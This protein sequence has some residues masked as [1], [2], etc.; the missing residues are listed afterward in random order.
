MKVVKKGITIIIS[1]VLWAI[2]LLAALFAFTTLATKNQTDVASLAG[3]TPMI[4]ES[5]SMAPTFCKGDLIVIRQCDTASL[6]EGDIITFHTIIENEYALNTHRI[7]SISEQNGVRS[8]VTKGDNNSIADT[9][10]ISDGDIV[11]KY[12]GKV[13]GLGKVM[14]FLSGSVGFLVIIVL[15]LLLFFIYQIY[16]LIMV[17]INLKKAIAVEEAKEKA[18]TEE[19]AEQS[20]KMQ[21]DAQAAKAEAEAV[22]A[23]AEAALAEAMRLKA[24]AEAALA[25][26]N[27]TKET[28]A[29][30]VEETEVN[31]AEEEE[32]K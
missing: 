11:G 23:E 24:E 30:N 5:D 19:S 21:E 12:I 2:I 3:F 8:Y 27:G 6:E 9:H 20:M 4:V 13:T 22:K 7:D 28:E 16:H 18:L 10:I 25:E 26:A 1:I 29:N 14:D 31:N 15:P 32:D 17:S